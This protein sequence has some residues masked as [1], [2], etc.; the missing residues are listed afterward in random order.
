[1]VPHALFAVPAVQTVPAQHP[2]GQFAGVHPGLPLLLLALE[3]ALLA[4]L[5]AALLAALDAAL[6]LALDAALLL[7]LEAALLALV[8]G[9]PPAPPVPAL[10]EAALEAPLPES[11]VVEAPLPDL[12]PPEPLGPVAPRPPAPVTSS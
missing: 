7:A 8:S 6:L 11:A 2:P 3:A 1:L 12:A 5:E 10:V 4:A 9:A